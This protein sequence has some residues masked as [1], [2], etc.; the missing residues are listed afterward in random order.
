[1]KKA[2]LLFIILV[3]I[4]V[5]SAQALSFFNLKDAPLTE[6][7]LRGMPVIVNYLPPRY[8]TFAPQTTQLTIN[9][10]DAAALSVVASWSILFI[11]ERSPR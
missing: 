9:Q 5:A 4:G 2:I 6:E 8:L 3:C 11:N 10:D 7:T 1:M